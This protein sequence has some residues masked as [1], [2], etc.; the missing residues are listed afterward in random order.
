MPRVGTWL[1]NIPDHSQWIS[2]GNGPPNIPN[3]VTYT[4]RTT[5]Q[6]VGVLP[7]TAVLQG[8]FIADNRVKAIRLNGREVFPDKK[9][10]ATGNL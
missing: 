9:R 2:I 10:P 5:F 3:N 6:L 7:Q 4:F 8:S 1:P